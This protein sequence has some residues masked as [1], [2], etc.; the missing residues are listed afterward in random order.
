MMKENRKRIGEMLLDAGLIDENQLSAAIGD[1]RQW[2][3]RLCSVLVRFGF[4]SE[5][6]VASFLERQLGE[7]CVSLKKRGISP[8]VLKKVPHDIADKYTIIPLE[9]ERGAL[10]LA[11]SDP[12]DIETIDKLGFMFGARIKPVLALESDIQKAI[13]HYY[14]GTPPEGRS[15]KG[16]HEQSASEILLMRDERNIPSYSPHEKKPLDGRPAGRERITPGM[17]IEALMEVLIEKG[18]ITEKEVEQKLGK[19][20]S[21]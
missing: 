2:G 21:H 12:T 6:T 7:K 11:I 5:Q 20:S 15:F 1:Q 19:R 13:A 3:G 17:M 8:E 4:V 18:L 10:T 9:F 14:G 16:G